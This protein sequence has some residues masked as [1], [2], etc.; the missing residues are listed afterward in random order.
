[1]S[2]NRVLELLKSFGFSSVEAEVYVFLAKAG[3]S[4]GRDLISGLNI[5][6][7]QLYPILKRLKQKG[8]VTHSSEH[9]SLFKAL[10]FEE[11]LNL[12]AELNVERAKIIQKT[13]EEL[14]DN[15]RNMKKN[16]N[17]Y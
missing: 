12:Y 2:L 4:K 3:P 14:L 11:L 10:T 5:V 6:K 17:G 1:M 16:N 15:W 8:I 9:P 7:Q 13:K